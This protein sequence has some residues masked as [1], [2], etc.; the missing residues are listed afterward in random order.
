MF[1]DRLSPNTYTNTN[2]NTKNLFLISRLIYFLFYFLDNLS[3][4]YTIPFSFPSSLLCERGS[5]YSTLF[6]TIG[7]VYS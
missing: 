1:H 7:L 6:P 4:F 2:T 5:R 3:Y